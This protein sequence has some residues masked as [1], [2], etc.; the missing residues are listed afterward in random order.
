MPSPVVVLAHAPEADAVARRVTDELAAL[1]YAVD[2][3]GAGKMRRAEAAKIES[4]RHVV[5]LWSRAARGTPALRAAVRRASARGTLVCVSLDAAPPPAGAKRVTRLPKSGAAW[6]SALV[7]KRPA[8]IVKKARAKPPPQRTR[9]TA[10]THGGGS[11][12]AIATPTPV[13]SAPILGFLA[14]VLVFGAAVGTG[15]YQTD[16]S[17]AAKVNALA[18]QAQAQVAAL[19]GKH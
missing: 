17:F 3:A 14:T 12:Q 15:L 4:A 5:V 13:R 2:C 1:G 11:V 18:G 16:A 8:Q 7:R 6:R 19:T 9:R 10:T